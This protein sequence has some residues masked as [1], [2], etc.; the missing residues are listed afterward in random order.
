MSLEGLKLLSL[1]HHMWRASSIS[2]VIE[3][4]DSRQVPMEY[5]IAYIA[6]FGITCAKYGHK[7]TVPFCMPTYL[8]MLVCAVVVGRISD[9]L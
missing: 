5:Y 2:T 6:T 3:I 7:A 8:N 4:P 9:G 1:L